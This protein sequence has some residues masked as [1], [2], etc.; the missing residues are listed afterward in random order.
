MNIYTRLIISIALISAFTSLANAEEAVEHTQHSQAYLKQR[1]LLLELRQSDPEAFAKKIEAHRKRLQTKM[2]NL[3]RTNP[4]KYAQVQARRQERQ[5]QFV[6]HVKE[7]NP[8]QYAE[9]MRRRQKFKRDQNLAE[10]TTRIKLN[11]RIN[12]IQKLKGETAQHQHL[13]TERIQKMRKDN[14]QRLN[15]NVDRP[16]KFKS[17]DNPL[18]NRLSDL[19]RKFDSNGSHVSATEEVQHNK[20]RDSRDL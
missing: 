6:Q 3:Q 18:K 5:A 17:N 1:E 16:Q 8:K 11:N 4:E 9:I 2:S 13:N 12:D 20:R 7:D 19:R 15:A 14:P 10:N